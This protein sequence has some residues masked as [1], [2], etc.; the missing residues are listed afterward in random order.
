M[1][2]FLCCSLLLSLACGAATA[3]DGDLDTSFSADGQRLIDTGDFVDVVHMAHAP[4]GGVFLGTTQRT[5]GN[6]DL[7]IYRLAAN[8]SSFSAFG[9]WGATRVGVDAVA[10]GADSMLAMF[11]DP[12]GS[13]LLVGTAEIADPEYPALMLV[14]LDPSG[15]PDPAFGDAGILL[16]EDNP[17]SEP[18]TYFSFGGALRLPDG[19]VLV[20]GAFDARDTGQPRRVVLRRVRA[21]GT[22]DTT[23]GPGGWASIV[24]DDYYPAIAPLVDREGRILLGV[25][26]RPPF[27]EPRGGSVI[28]FTAQGQLDTTFGADGWVALPHEESITGVAALAL[29]TSD[30][31]YAAA[32]GLD[33]ES[34]TYVALRRVLPDGSFDAAYGPD[35]SLTIDLE[36]GI[37]ISAMHVRPDGRTVMVGRIDHTGG[38]RD[39]F[40]A[41]V[42]ADG[43]LD[44][45]FDANGVARFALDPDATDVA[46]S[47]LLV[48]GKPVIAGRSGAD[49]A[50]IAMMRLQSDWMFG[51]GLE[52]R[53]PQ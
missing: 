17:W 16:L 2:F 32:W 48:A 20:S 6:E 37:D 34:R 33:I 26:R 41:R 29:D 21:D 5:D 39:M 43:R 14:R 7:L 11:S 13:L 42:T 19:A 12:D 46:H 44:P 28:R 10:D 27:S 22:P 38:T 24:V 50:S 35:G 30:R 49:N 31:V 3:A 40:A 36:G 51:D 53:G 1:R 8:G 52:A 15:D 25:S 9:T 45:D 18:D 47:V 23:F 4:D